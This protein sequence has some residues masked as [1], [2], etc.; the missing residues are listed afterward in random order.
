MYFGCITESTVLHSLIEKVITAQFES[1][2]LFSVEQERLLEE[3]PN[4]KD[5]FAD[6]LGRNEKRTE[7]FKKELNEWENQ[8]SFKH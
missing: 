8:K 2:Q 3:N 5:V 4:L 6:Q 1:Q 7:L